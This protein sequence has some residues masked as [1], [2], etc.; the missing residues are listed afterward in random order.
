MF[1]VLH[2][3]RAVGGLILV[4][5]YIQVFNVEVQHGLLIYEPKTLHFPLIVS[6]EL[7]FISFSFFLRSFFF[8]IF[9]HETDFVLFLQTLRVPN[10]QQTQFAFFYISFRFLRGFDFKFQVSRESSLTLGFVLFFPGSF[11]IVSSSK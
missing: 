2:S 7:N 3:R 11:R 8:L 6:S 5:N 4:L 10:R 1:T 9:E